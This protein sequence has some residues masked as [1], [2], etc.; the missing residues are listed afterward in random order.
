MALP[1]RLVQPA[2]DSIVFRVIPDKNDAL[3]ALSSGQLQLVADDALDA[4]DA[5]VLDSLPGVQARY[6]PGN[7][8]EH[9]TF[10][11]D[12]PTL[13]ES[14][15]RQAIAY[16]I[17]RDALNADVMAGK[18]EVSAGQVPSWSWA[19]DSTVSKYDTSLQRANQLLDGAGW[20]R[21]ADGVRTRAGQRLSFK[22]W[23]TPASFRPAL[24]EAIKA[25]LA[26]VGIELNVDMIPSAALFDTSGT[27]AKS[28]VG[29]QFD[30]VEFAWI[31]TYD[32][33]TDAVYNTHSLSVPSKTNGFQGG[34]YGDYK[35]PRIDQLLNQMQ[36]SLDPAF[37]RIAL[38]EAQTI[39]QSDLPVL[40]LLLRPIVTASS[41]T[42]TNVRPTPAPAGVTWNVEQWAITAPN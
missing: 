2:L 18:A 34:N 33:G 14:N 19:F 7:A 5:P 39:W 23:S 31:S 13:A 27:E 41:A 37:R 1:Q 26:Q 17:N 40:P 6:T 24:M 15:L 10:N 32:P 20:T 28:L 22:Y 29:R 4:G 3:T 16:A 36:S 8:W 38:H 12:N 42:L 11:L 35:N 21:A 25:E 30:I 9:L